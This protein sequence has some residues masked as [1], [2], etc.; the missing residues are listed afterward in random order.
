MYIF[1]N[2]TCFLS[3]K[4]S[5]RLISNQSMGL[6]ISFLLLECV[7][8]QHPE[9]PWQLL[10]CPQHQDTLLYFLLFKYFRNI[11]IPIHNPVNLHIL[12]SNLIQHNIIPANHIFI[13][14]LEAD[15]L[16]K[17]SPHIGKL[18]YILNLS[19]YLLNGL[20]CHF[21]SSSKLIQALSSLT[22]SSAS[23]SFINSFFSAFS[24]S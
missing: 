15:S 7:I 3:Y 1:Q 11:L 24:R 14:R 8:K 10:R 4:K 22:A 17:T 2:K 19:I 23:C 21:F 5:H 16:S 20:Y 9:L 18:L 13:I 6:S 12:F